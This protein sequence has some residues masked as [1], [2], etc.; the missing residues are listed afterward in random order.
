MSKCIRNTLL[1]NQS[2]HPHPNSICLSTIGCYLPRPTNYSHMDSSYIHL[3]PC[4]DGH[5]DGRIRQGLS[6][7]TVQSIRTTIQ[8]WC[9]Q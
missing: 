7:I 9:G 6:T 1:S 5:Q 8:L 4:R 2:T 3:H